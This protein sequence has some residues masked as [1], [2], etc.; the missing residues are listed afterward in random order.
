[1]TATYVV[2]PDLFVGVE[3]NPL[4]NDVGPLA[5]WRVLD[6]TASRPALILGTSSDRIG[7]TSGRAYFATLS[8]DVEDW[9]GL[10]I[11]PY[12]GV[13]YGEFEDELREIAGMSVRW[14]DR[15]TSTHIWDGVNLHHLMDHSFDSGWRAGIVAVEQDGDFYFGLSMGAS[16]GR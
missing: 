12:V 5:T 16:L 2:T 13:T 15:W 9:T 3:V 8:K 14:H 10:P 4:D 6:E 7:S 11:A 1:M